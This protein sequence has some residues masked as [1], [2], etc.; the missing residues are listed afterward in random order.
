MDSLL[1]LI[2][3]TGAVLLAIISLSRFVIACLL[4]ERYTGRSDVSYAASMGWTIFLYT[5]SVFV[6][7]QALIE[8]TYNIS[9]SLIF[10]LVP[11]L[12]VGL[13]TFVLR[14]LGVSGQNK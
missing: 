5:F 7:R 11:S 4:P 3:F 1:S 9:V 14:A 12:V 6:A 10:A 2:F 8:S 13:G